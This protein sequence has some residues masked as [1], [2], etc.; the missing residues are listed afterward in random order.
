MFNLFTGLFVLYE[1]QLAYRKAGGSPGRALEKSDGRR[2][3]GLT[4]AKY[5]LLA[6]KLATDTRAGPVSEQ[7][8]SFGADF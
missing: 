1:I 4:P 6:R 8:I 5:L 3:E 7:V 2:M